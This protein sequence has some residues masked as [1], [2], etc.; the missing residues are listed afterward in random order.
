MV[1]LK[2]HRTVITDGQRLAINTT[3]NPGMATG[4][5]GDVLTG[6]IAAL[7]AQH[8]RRSTRPGWALTSTA[9]PATWRPGRGTGGHHRPR[10]GRHLP[11]RMARAVGRVRNGDDSAEAISVSAGPRRG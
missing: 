10:S 1:L 6:V 2:G 3:G 9:W 7:L 8:L 4:G 5:T 11:A